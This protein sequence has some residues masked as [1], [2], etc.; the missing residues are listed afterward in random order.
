MTTTASPLPSPRTK[1]DYKAY[2]PLSG[3]ITTEPLDVDSPT[4][5]PV[6][7]SPAK[8]HILK[9][10][11]SQGSNGSTSA[12]AS[13]VLKTPTSSNIPLSPSSGG[14]RTPKART[15]ALKPEAE[16]SHGDG[17]TQQLVSE[18][19]GLQVQSPMQDPGGPRVLPQVMNGQTAPT[20][21]HD[22]S[23]SSSTDSSDASGYPHP[24]PPSQL[25]S[26]YG[27][28]GFEVDGSDE[29]ANGSNGTSAYGSTASQMSAHAAAVVAAADEA[30]KQLNG[31][32]TVFQN[33]QT[34]GLSPIDNSFQLP[35][36][37]ANFV[38]PQAR[39]EPKILPDHLVHRQS[40]TS[41]STTEASTS[42]EESD[43]CIP[44]IEWVHTGH[45]LPHS[46][47]VHNPPFQ[48]PSRASPGRSPGRMAPPATTGRG[49]VLPRKGSAAM[50]GAAGQQPRP[51]SLHHQESLP[52]GATAQTPS[53]LRQSVSV[54]PAGPPPNVQA[55]DDDDEATV[56][57][58]RDRSSS[59]SSQSVQSGLDLLWRAA[60][61]GPEPPT[62]PYNNPY[63]GKGKRKA[64]AEAV[65]Q[66]RSSG[67]PTGKPGSGADEQARAKEQEAMPQP[68]PKKRRRSGFLEEI[69]PA[70]R[71]MEHEESSAMEQDQEG[72]D[73]HSGSVSDEGE[74][75]SG[76]DSEYGG[77][78][79]PR[80]RAA[81]RG[82]SGGKKG[83]R[84]RVSTGTGTGTA[85]GS[86]SNRTNGPKKGRRSGE[87][88]SGSRRG[89]GGGGGRASAA[90]S[91]VG[92]QC[93]YVNPLPVSEIHNVSGM[94]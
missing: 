35:R 86:S 25:G 12:T 17:K 40:S 18:M 57:H 8:A 6:P 52:L 68:P 51:P 75:A 43:L 48:Q 46:P 10:V 4:D 9:R 90:L 42:S 3:I 79:M 19:D 53:G 44:S 78:G 88:P 91:G 73:Y 11:L 70:L 36:G 49:L 63:D 92:V 28:E 62:S 60:T 16:L 5:E 27:P 87:S 38:R 80:E 74:G 14:V 82:R 85:A 76:D 7:T 24:V 32:A 77:G 93:E 94:S 15:A 71:H 67:I 45:G 34:P 26:Q 81:G 89:G 59:T 83:G 54:L 65:A 37:Y 31:T 33:P 22:R 58:G 20:S 55:E 64:G 1:P 30:I 23:F 61:H 50:A 29:P 72:S 41:S 21:G 69:D 84:A 47:M 39:S 66:W 2:V 13:A 56:G